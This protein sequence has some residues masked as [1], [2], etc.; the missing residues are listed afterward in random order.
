[1]ELEEK[2]KSNTWDN[3]DDFIGVLQAARE[4]KWQWL[5]NTRCKYVELRVDMRDGG[6]IIRDRHG[7]RIDPKELAYQ[8]GAK[9]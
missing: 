4:G 5:W 9:P 6:C 2:I 7:N 1:M 3:I 8:Y